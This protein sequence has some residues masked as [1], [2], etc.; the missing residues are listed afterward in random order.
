MA[1]P[2]DCRENAAC[3]IEMANDAL[4]TDLQSVLFEMANLWLKLAAE[5]ERC[6]DVGAAYRHLDAQRALL[7]DRLMSSH[8]LTAA[9]LFK[10]VPSGGTNPLQRRPSSPTMLVEHQISA[11]S[12]GGAAV[13]PRRERNDLAKN[14]TEALI[15]FVGR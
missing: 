5:L 3:C 8:R 1:D 4:N 15:W 12:D 6:A 7:C 2:K 14:P 11:V 13:R 10:H 9:L